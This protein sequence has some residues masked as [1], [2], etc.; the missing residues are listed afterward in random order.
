MQE[1]Y[2]EVAETVL[3]YKDNR[4]GLIRRTVISMIPS[5]A[6]YNPQDFAAL[7]LHKC[8]LHLLGQLKKDRDRSVGGLNYS[9][10]CVT[11]TRMRY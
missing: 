10:Y 8:M 11:E 9:A 4:D 6:V 1:K 7:Y 2:R 3:R 5:L